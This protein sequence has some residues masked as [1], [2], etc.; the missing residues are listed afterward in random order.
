MTLFCGQHRV[1]PISVDPQVVSAYFRI[2]KKSNFVI[3][4]KWVYEG[5]PKSQFTMSYE[6][7]RSI[8]IKGKLS[9]TFGLL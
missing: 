8:E 3:I 5:L 2:S 4:T 7:V 9:T 6:L 1:V